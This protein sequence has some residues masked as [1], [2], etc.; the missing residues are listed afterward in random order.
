MVLDK[1]ILISI[2][3]IILVNFFFVK[4]YH[5]FFLRKTRDN[6]FSKPQAFHLK[7]IPRMGGF[8]IYISLTIFLIIFEFF[9]KFLFFI[10]LY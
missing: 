2:P 9:G 1:V 5:L 10:G 8:L 3:L 4:N 7:S 6:K